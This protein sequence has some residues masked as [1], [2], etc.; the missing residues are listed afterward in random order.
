[1]Q[2]FILFFFIFPRSMSITPNV[3][4]FPLSYVYYPECYSGPPCPMFITPNAIRVLLV[5]CLLPR[6]L[7]GSPLSYVYYPECIRVPLVL[8][9]L[10][11]MYSGIPVLAGMPLSQK[12]SQKAAPLLHNPKYFT[13]FA[14][15][16]QTIDDINYLI[17]NY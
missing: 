1:M 6:M 11:R 3:F 9:L 14:P 13:T 12:K 17:I 2:V 15:Q 16:S 8:C 4:G 5:L 7:F 10:P